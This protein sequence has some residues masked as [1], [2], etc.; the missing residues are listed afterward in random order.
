MLMVNCYRLFVETFVPRNE[1]Y[2]FNIGIIYLTCER[3]E[4]ESRQTKKAQKH[5]CISYG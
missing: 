1:S 4:A 3:L 2:L 5:H